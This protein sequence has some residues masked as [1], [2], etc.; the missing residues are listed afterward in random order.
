MFDLSLLK[1][2][3]NTYPPATFEGILRVENEL[4]VIIPDIYKNFLFTTNGAEA[5]LF[6]LYDIDG[7]IEMN[8]TYEVQ[9]YAPGYISIGNDGG[10]YHLLMKAEKSAK[11]FI[12]VSDGYGV[13][14]EDDCKDVF[15]D[16][17][18]SQDG[19]PW[20]NERRK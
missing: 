18:F 12:L 3:Q 20:R 5:N 1:H 11:E 4:D 2:L 6:T 19:N 7:L 16:W 10:G 14:S 17:L 15:D 9:E 8:I 13:P